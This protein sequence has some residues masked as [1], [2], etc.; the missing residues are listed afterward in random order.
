L[1]EKLLHFCCFLINF[2]MYSFISELAKS[3]LPYI[4]LLTKLDHTFSLPQEIKGFPLGQPLTSPTHPLVVA[5]RT[6]AALPIPQET[7]A[8]LQTELSTQYGSC[9][10]EGQGNQVLVIRVPRDEPDMI[11]DMEQAVETIAPAHVTDA[12]HCVLVG[13]RKI[14]AVP[15]EPMRQLMARRVQLDQ[16]QVQALRLV[17]PGTLATH[18]YRSPDDPKRRLR[19]GVGLP[20]ERVVDAED[21]DFDELARLLG[22]EITARKLDGL[23]CVYLVSSSDHVRLQ[24]DAFVDDILSK[25]QNEEHLAGIARERAEKERAEKARRINDREKLLETLEVKKSR[26]VVRAPMTN[27]LIEAESEV[28]ASARE[29]FPQRVERLR[30]RHAEFTSQVREVQQTPRSTLKHPATRNLHDNVDALTGRVH[31][32]ESEYEP[33]ITATETRIG[34]RTHSD[35]HQMLER[36]GYQVLDAPDVPG[37]ELSAAAERA[38]AY[39]QRLIILETSRFTMEDAETLLDASRALGPDMAL[40]I[41]EQIDNEARGL[42]LASKVKWVRLNELHRLTL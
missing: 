26:R 37:Y 13:G 36:N 40:A 6:K 42:I 28:T 32:A 10:W 24:P 34:R 11:A 35:V 3:V 21:R 22:P 8:D 5:V 31:E 14:I 38:G 25:W 9:V 1:L 29:P 16:K 7:I 2:V 20:M 23:H 39:P 30:E 4:F 15:M 27:A 17:L 41:G 18:L 12:R 33:E 19:L